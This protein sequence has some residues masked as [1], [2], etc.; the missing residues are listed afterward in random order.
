MIYYGLYAFPFLVI[1]WSLGLLATS[2]SFL[3]SPSL[4]HQR[5][6]LVLLE[7]VGFLRSFGHLLVLA[8]YRLGFCVWVD[9]FLGVRIWVTVLWFL[10]LVEHGRSSKIDSIHS[11]GVV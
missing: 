2:F 6:P 8:P 3:L 9:A 7:L 4:S 10:G 11:P 5:H 1:M